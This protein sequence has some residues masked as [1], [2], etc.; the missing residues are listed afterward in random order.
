MEPEEEAGI[1][2][3]ETYHWSIEESPVCCFCRLMLTPGFNAHCCHMGTPIKHHVPD[4]VKPS[5]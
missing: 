5:F 4:R 3:V 1:E 2:E